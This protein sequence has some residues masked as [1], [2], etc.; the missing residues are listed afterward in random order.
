MIPSFSRVFDWIA[1]AV[2]ALAFAAV[3]LALTSFS[4][5]A[6]PVLLDRIVVV[7]NDGVILQSELDR[8]IGISTGQLRERGIAAPSDT[9]LRTQVLDRL[10]NARVQT[11][12]AQEGGIK[13]DDRELNEV[14]GNIAQQNKM[15]LA[16]FAEAIRKD[17]MDFLAVR[18]QIRDEVLIARVKQQEVDS[19]VVVTDQDIDLFLANHQ[20]LDD[21]EYR[22]SAILVAVPE[23]ATPEQREKSRAKAE[24]LK[25]RLDKGEDF[26]QLAAAESDGQQALQGGDLDWRKGVN[27]PTVFASAAPKLKIGETSNVLESGAGYHL[28]KLT[29]KRGDGEQQSVSETKAQHILLMP[30]TIRD[31]DATLTQARELEKR[32]KSGEDFDKLAKEFSDDPGSKN[33]GGDLGFQP[34]GIF[35]PEFQIRVDQLQPGE[36]SAPF[37]TQFGWHIVRVNERRTR[38]TSVETRR[39][40]ARAAIGQRKSSEE[41]DTWLRRLR[42]EAYVEF[43]G[44]NGKAVEPAAEAPKAS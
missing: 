42:D 18:E 37:H 23:G 2:R 9:V 31:E 35:A 44:A 6:E 38:D 3:S 30:N 29:A 34:P 19:R 21:T 15:S 26:A 12:K 4:V 24:A 8:A 39:A 32:L 10:V 43:R 40:K 14:L 20:N 28:I 11:Q 22:L 36:T 41:Y 33:A 27:L 16:E 13:I 17:G 1:I 5:Q 25:V 7:V